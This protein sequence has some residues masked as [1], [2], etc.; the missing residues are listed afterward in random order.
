MVL[1]ELHVHVAI[2]QQAHVVQQLARRDRPRAFLLHPRR[3]GAADAQFQVRGGQRQPVVR[4]FQKHVRENWYGGFLLHYALRQTQ[5]TYQIALVDGE[6]HAH[7]S[8]TFLAISRCIVTTAF[9][10]AVQPVREYLNYTKLNYFPPC[11]R[12]NREPRKTSKNRSCHPICTVLLMPHK[13]AIV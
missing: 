6:F 2:R 11:L 9:K 13:M 7:C 3:A 12:E 10:G 5:L 8:S 4:R 1:Q